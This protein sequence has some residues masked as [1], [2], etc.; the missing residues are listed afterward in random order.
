M[1]RPTPVTLKEER[2][3]GSTDGRKGFLF[4]HAFGHIAAER[5]G[6]E[7]KKGLVSQSLVLGPRLKSSPP[8]IRHL[9]ETPHATVSGKK[10]AFSPSIPRILF[11]NSRVSF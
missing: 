11:Y 2:K 8:D 10:V 5:R 3:E 1:A 4:K 6:E 9:T 7:N